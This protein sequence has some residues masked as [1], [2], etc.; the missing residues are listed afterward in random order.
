MNLKN[1]GMSIPAPKPLKEHHINIDARRPYKIAAEHPAPV[2]SEISFPGSEPDMHMTTLNYLG[3]RRGDIRLRAHI[4]A[5]EIRENPFNN[6]QEFL[7][8]HINRAVARYAAENPGTKI[9]PR[10]SR[11]YV[12]EQDESNRNHTENGFK[13]EY[14]MPLFS[15]RQ[16]TWVSGYEFNTDTGM[17]D[18]EFQTAQFEISGD[19][20]SDEM[21]D[22][23]GN[24]YF[25]DAGI[26]TDPKAH[27]YRRRLLGLQLKL[28]RRS[29]PFYNLSPQERKALGT[30]REMVSETDFRKYLKY[31]FVIVPAISGAQYQI[32]RNRSHVKVW[33][34]GKCIE[35][36]CV[37]IANHSIPQTDKIIAFKTMIE[38]DEQEFKTFGNVYKMARAA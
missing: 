12:T 36:I 19:P 23:F 7:Q 8:E 20:P 4:P 22:N 18:V 13:I 17:L 27:R 21:L 32:F 31:G 29:S 28:P 9:C 1:S 2:F 5:Y 15:S 11:S 10:E 16:N 30:L 24:L 3:T 38:A 26:T 14:K 34:N 37:N 33:K 6:P 35:E 25:H